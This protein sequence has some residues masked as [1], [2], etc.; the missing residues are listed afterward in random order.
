MKHVAIL[1]LL[2]VFLS[3][4]TAQQDTYSCNTNSDCVSTCGLGC[5]N[6]EWVKVYTDTCVNIRAFECSC[7]NNLCHSDGN[8]PS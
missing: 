7:V 8:P 5:V 2:T 6:S 1:L 3:G 4:C